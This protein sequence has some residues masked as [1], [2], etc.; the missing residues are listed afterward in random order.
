MTSNARRRLTRLE[1]KTTAPT[2]K[3]IK[4]VSFGLVDDGLYHGEGGEVFTAA[5]FAALESEY[6]FIVVEY[7]DWPRDQVAS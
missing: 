6:Q 5:E 7:G 4:I 1:T 2:V 3:R